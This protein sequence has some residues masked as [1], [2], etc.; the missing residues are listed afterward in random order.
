MG[1][2]RVEC[3]RGSGPLPTAAAVYGRARHGPHSKK[4]RWGR[5]GGDE[6][7]QPIAGRAGRRP[8]GPWRRAV[9]L[10]LG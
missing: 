6:E 5:R 4:T 3:G 9:G 1:K 8:S 7:M 2:T 10:G